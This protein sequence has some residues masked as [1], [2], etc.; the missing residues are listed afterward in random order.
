ME[1]KLQVCDAIVVGV[2]N[3]DAL[4][5]GWGGDAVPALLRPLQSPP[6]LKLAYDT[7]LVLRNN[8]IL[9]RRGLNIYFTRKGRGLKKS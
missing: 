2:N 6:L 5:S 1:D 9:Y 3:A 7:Y 8:R 4:I